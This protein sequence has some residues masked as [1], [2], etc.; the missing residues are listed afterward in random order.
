MSATFRERFT[1]SVSL[2]LSMLSKN[3][4]LLI[5]FGSLGAIALGMWLCNGA[6]WPAGQGTTTSADKAL[7]LAGLAALVV[8]FFLGFLFGIPRVV[9]DTDGTPD[10]DS[11][12][13]HN[14]AQRVNTNLEQISDWLTK[15]IVGVGLVEM[16]DAPAFMWKV[17]G[18]MSRSFSKDGQVDLSTAP[19]ICSG[20]IFFAVLGLLLGYLMTR[21]YFAT[22]FARADQKASLE[23]GFETSIL[24]A[25][26]VPIGKAGLVL[27]KPVSSLGAKRIL[28]TLKRYQKEHCAD[29]RTKR[30]TFSILPGASNYP[31]FV[32]GLG[33]LL[34][35]GLVVVSPANN[36][37]MLSDNGL[38][39][40]DGTEGEKLEGVELYKF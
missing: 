5:G 1:S 27:G 10:V 20:V 36:H 11:K 16:K 3:P 32:K 31:D 19:I 2:L 35:N 25:S 34:E 4:A 17:A 14:Y 29:D 8:G 18:Q 24:P 30:W 28:A 37:V 22:A 12:P 9:Q 40:V 7:T 21:L 23:R 39:Y 26:E 13:K 6:I 33:E 15:I 38:T